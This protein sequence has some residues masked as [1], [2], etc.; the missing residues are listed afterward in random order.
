[1]RGFSADVC[2]VISW[3]G[4]G[5]EAVAGSQGSVVRRPKGRD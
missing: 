5:A 4:G 3:G 2:G 1:L